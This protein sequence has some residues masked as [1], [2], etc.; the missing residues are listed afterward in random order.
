MH[1]IWPYLKIRGEQDYLTRTK[2][3]KNKSVFHLGSD[4][5]VGVSGHT[6]RFTWFSM[7]GFRENFTT[8]SNQT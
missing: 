6:F 4:S 3:V 1:T 2:T 7:V 5:L 8:I